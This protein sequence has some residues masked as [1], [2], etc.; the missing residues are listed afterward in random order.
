MSDEVPEAGVRPI[1]DAVKCKYRDTSPPGIP[2]LTYLLIVVNVLL[3]LPMMFISWKLLLGGS[4]AYMATFDLLKTLPKTACVANLGCLG[5]LV[6]AM[7][8]HIGFLHFAGNMAFL[9]LIGDN[10]ELTLGRLRFLIIYF[11]AGIVGGLVQATI[12]LG[13]EGSSAPFM[14]AGA[15][16]AISGLVGSYLVL[17][18]GST[19]CACFGWGL[20]YYCFPVRAAVL[21]VAWIGLQFV[22]ALVASSIGVY[23]HLAGL[24]AGMALTGL[25]ADRQL[26]DKVRSLI[27]RGIVRGHPPSYYELI[28]PS[29]S[30]VCK[31]VIVAS[32]VL[33]AALSGYALPS[34]AEMEGKYY[35]IYAEY[36]YS[37][38][39]T[40]YY[41]VVLTFKGITSMWAEINNT[42][43]SHVLEKFPYQYEI[44]Y[45]HYNGTP[46]FIDPVYYVKLDH[47]SE[48]GL[49]SLLIVTASIILSFRALSMPEKYEVTYIPG[50][51]EK[52]RRKLVGQGWSPRHS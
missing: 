1:W 26:I 2:W 31:L 15:S 6:F 33:L 39:M 37:T 42:A 22:Y 10:V 21:L 13:V 40:E 52:R 8:I 43:P 3:F 11:V 12:S 49:L 32:A 27:E 7:F 38:R 14:I 35:V 30:K 24:F 5:Q 9:Y 45:K 28:V 4:E 36:T 48:A 16:A 47:T 50:L 44:Y 18:P 51:K 23:A 34:L 41:S 25:L 17:Y 29:L 20:L 19:M 46:T